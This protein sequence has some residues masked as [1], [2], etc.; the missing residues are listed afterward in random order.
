MTY[1]S[2]A[3]LLEALSGRRVAVVGDAMLDVYVWGRVERISPE[4]PVPIVAVEDAREE[5]RAGGA[6]NVARGIVALAGTATLVALRGDDEAGGQLEALLAK[7]GV[8]VRFAVDP[9]R[10]TTTK[11]RVVAGQQQIVRLDR[12][13]T[14]PVSGEV[15]QALRAAAREAV[16]EAEALVLSD[17]DKGALTR[18]LLE[19]TIAAALAR[20]LSIVVDPNV[21]HFFRY[22]RATVIAP[23]R[24]ELERATGRRIRDEAA[25]VAVAKEARARLAEK[26]GARVLPALLVTRGE[27]GMTL[28]ADGAPLHIPT[29][30]RQVYDVTG[31]GDTVVATL[32][33]A[34]AAGADLEE[35][36][37]LAN[38]AAGVVVGKRGAATVTREEIADFAADVAAAGGAAAGGAAGR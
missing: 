11:T 8:D 16:E 38:E 22:G 30:A 34:L 20:G 23:N 5:R 36:A 19:E 27:E 31:A 25:L 21:E 4:A 15:A 37:R 17:Y 33:L 7:D 6:A 24:Y 26:A 32:S 9:N 1:R 35:A 14:D 10:P 28:F 13:R 12:E 18:E 2:R 29:V 3:E